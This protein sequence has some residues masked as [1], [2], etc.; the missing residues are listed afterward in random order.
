M[1]EGDIN[2]EPNFKVFASILREYSGDTIKIIDIEVGSIRLII[3]G[4]QE[5]IERLISRFRAGEIKKLDQFSVEDIQILSETDEEN[6]ELNH[7]WRLVQEIV[8]HGVIGRQLKGVD[9]SDTDLSGAD[10]SRAYLSGANLSEAYLSN[11]SGANLSGA[12]VQYARFGRNLGTS[13]SMKLDLI[14][15]GAI[16]EDSA[17]DRSPTPSGF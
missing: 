7:K 5:E 9:L 15:R 12:E 10:L 11:L 14:K 3:E 16:F 13:D 6:R 2:S 17:G 8:S 1:L 4:S